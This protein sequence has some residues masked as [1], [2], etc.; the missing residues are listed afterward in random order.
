[1]RSKCAM[2]G[3]QVATVAD[4]IEDAYRKH[5]VCGT[6]DP[7]DTGDLADILPKNQLILSTNNIPDPPSSVTAATRLEI[8]VLTLD[9]I[10]SK[11]L[12]VYISPM[13][14]REHP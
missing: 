13:H 7:N 5:A 8:S 3:I 14:H 1:M 12:L 4:F 2:V 9:P 6:A 10:V 11:F